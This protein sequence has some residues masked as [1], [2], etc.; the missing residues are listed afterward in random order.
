MICNQ[1]KEFTWSKLWP[2]VPTTVSQNENEPDVPVEC[3]DKN[4]VSLLNGLVGGSEIQTN[5]IAEW[6]QGDEE[7][8]P[9]LSEDDIVA[10]CSGRQ[11]VDFS[12]DDDDG[13]LQ[14]NNGPNH[15]EATR[16]FE[17]LMVYLEKQEETSQLLLFKRLRDLVA[18]K[19]CSHTKQKI[20]SHFFTLLV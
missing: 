3:S 6:I 20:I 15:S 7:P 18:K 13:S 8:H 5:D 16:M 1:N 9:I 19:R 2:N 10:E 14:E 17:D 4:F 12:S 11:A